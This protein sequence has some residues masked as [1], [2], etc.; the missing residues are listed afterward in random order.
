MEIWKNNNLLRTYRESLPLEDRDDYAEWKKD[1]DLRNTSEY[2]RSKLKN[3]LDINDRVKERNLRYTLGKSIKLTEAVK[4]KSPDST[5]KKYKSDLARELTAK[6]FPIWSYDKED[7]KVYRSPLT[8]LHDG[9]YGNND[10]VMFHSFGGDQ[11]AIE[12]GH[13]YD[14]ACFIESEG[15]GEEYFQNTNSSI[16]SEGYNTDDNFYYQGPTWRVRGNGKSKDFLKE[17]LSRSQIADAIIECMKK[18]CPNRDF[19]AEWD[20]MIV[21]INDKIT[22]LDEYIKEYSAKLAVDPNKVDSSG[23]NWKDSWFRDKIENNIKSKE[24]RI[25]ELTSALQDPDL[26]P[27]YLSGSSETEVE[28]KSKNWYGGTWISS[29]DGKTSYWITT[30]WNKATAIRQVK[31]SSLCSRRSYTGSPKDPDYLAAS[32]KCT[33]EFTSDKEAKAWSDSHY[34]FSI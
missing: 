31:H 22:E 13:G 16:P 27:E 29:Y 34:A 6:H 8:I 19:D 15:K 28:R 33:K 25:K 9:L 26:S 18:S 23:I 11:L 3:Q 4:Y 5:Y 1:Y 30:A 7:K 17:G 14:I 2:K 24:K 32:V 12:P 21:D 20:Q 10:Y